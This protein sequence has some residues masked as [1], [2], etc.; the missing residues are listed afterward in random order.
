MGEMYSLRPGDSRAR[1][2]SVDR[3]LPTHGAAT[4]LL[5]ALPRNTGSTRITVGLF[6]ESLTRIQ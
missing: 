4:G 3:R 1:G 2:S 5:A 6:G